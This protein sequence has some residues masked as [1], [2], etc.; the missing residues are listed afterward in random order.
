M[1]FI[2][3]V[4]LVGRVAR[5]PTRVP[6]GGYVFTLFQKQPFG[7]RGGEIPIYPIIAGQGEPPSFLQV[8]Q[9][10]IVVGRVRT[11]NFQQSVRRLVA[12]ALR[13]AGRAEDA[14]AIADQLPP[15]LR[16]PRVA[17][18]IVADHILAVDPGQNRNTHTQKEQQS[19]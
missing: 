19:P 6:G 13:R 2:N 11:R 10:V 1:S 7:E 12:K 5:A 4:T 14:D 17:M 3:Q 16:E 18:E 9:L 8:N 15:T